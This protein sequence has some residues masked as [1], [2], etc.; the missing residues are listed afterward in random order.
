VRLSV[1][2]TPIGNLED[3]SLRAAR[4]LREAD[5]VLAEDTRSARVL[6]DRCDGL[7][8]GSNDQ[9]RVI[10]VFEGNEAS[11][12]E[13]ALDAIRAG[14][15]VA[16][17]SEAGMPG[18]SDPGARVVKAAIDAGVTIEIV[19]GPV[20]A[21]AALVASGLP[22]DRFLFVG[23]PPREAG[24][25]QEAFG[26]LRGERATMIFYEAP[27]RTGATLA[28][29]A[30]AMGGEREACVS[31]E[32]TKVHEEHAR[33]T[34]ADLADRYAT[35][36]PRGEVTIVVGG[37]IATAPFVDVEAEL[38]A[39]LDQGLGPKDAAARLVVKTGAPR[40]RLYQLA[41]AIQRAK[42]RA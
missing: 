33:G 35:T 37:A 36:P 16:L 1:V 3:L 32:I 4:V 18:V 6:L 2:A 10:S 22:T 7:A 9:R 20:A 17:I 21:I 26:A 23:F 24:A 31:R 15:K 41:L 27:D 8:P 28:D 34:L 19:P 5:L 39:L 38:G 42:G 13:T 25:R 12:I 40:R 29:L 11:R 14:K 30:A